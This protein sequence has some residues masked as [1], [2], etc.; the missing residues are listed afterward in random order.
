VTNTALLNH[1]KTLFAGSQQRMGELQ[2][3]SVLLIAESRAQNLRSKEIMNQSRLTREDALRIRISLCVS[4]E[5][6]SE[7]YCQLFEVSEAAARGKSNL[8]DGYP[9]VK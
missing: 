7:L 4:K 8:I 5:A 6:L 3:E 2:D 1:K 9:G